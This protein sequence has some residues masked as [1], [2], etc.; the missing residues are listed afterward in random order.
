MIVSISEQRTTYWVNWE[1]SALVSAY[2]T[3][4]S[5]GEWYHEALD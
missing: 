5:D 2:Y 4:I 3:H 1:Q